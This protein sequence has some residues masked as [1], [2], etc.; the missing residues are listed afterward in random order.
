MSLI[1]PHSFLFN[2]DILHSVCFNVHKEQALLGTGPPKNGGRRVMGSRFAFLL[3]GASAVTL[4]AAA[5]WAQTPAPPSAP[6]PAEAA[7]DEKVVVTGRKREEAIQKLPASATV[8]GGDQLE[9]TQQTTADQVLRTVPNALTTPFGAEYASDVIIRG[10]GSGRSETSESATGIYRNGAYAAGGG[11]GG[12]TLTRMDL[13]DIG[14]LEIFR[15]PQGAS[16]GRNAVGGAINVVSARPQDRLLGSLAVAADDVQSVDIRGVFNAPVGKNAALRLGGLYQAQDDGFYQNADGST[17]DDFSVYGGRASLGFSLSETVNGVF[18]IEASDEDTPSFTV[19]GRYPTVSPLFVRNLNTIPR[20]L[21]DTITSS[22]EMNWDTGIGRFTSVT[23]MR[24]RNLERLD[25]FDASVRIGAGLLTATDSTIDRRDRFE[26]SRFSQELRLSSTIGENVW[27]ILGGE[28]LTSAEDIE[29]RQTGANNTV[30][31]LFGLPDFVTLGSSDDTSWA[32]FGLLGWRPTEAWELT[33]EVRATNDNKTY[34]GQRTQTSGAGA[35]TIRDA[36]NQDRDFSNVS[37]VATLSWSPNANVTGYARLATGYRAGGFNIDS[38]AGNP[39]TQTFDPEDSVSYE[40]GAKTTWF[41]NLLRLNLAAYRMETSDIQ[42]INRNTTNDRYVFNAGDAVVQGL[43][44]D[45]RIFLPLSHQK[46]A[47]LILFGGSLNESE[48]LNGVLQNGAV[49][50]QLAGLEV[51]RA[52]H[53]TANLFVQYR[54]ALWEGSQLR[55]SGSYGA[56]WGGF[57]NPD[58]TEKLKSFQ[59]ADFS[60]GVAFGP[61]EASLYVQNAFDYLF[62]VEQFGGSEFINKPRVAGVRLKFS[63]DEQ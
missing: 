62:V 63:Y 40:L 32:A 27:L 25:D 29:L 6:A 61:W 1:A 57:E 19:Y 48:N 8:V 55:L 53:A 20:V 52:R 44:L 21:T 31:N 30:S 11:A 46:E 51:P 24:D 22:L 58:N 7:Q 3:A 37:P 56:Q 38:Q 33:G 35:G 2:V 42:L 45:G 13:F 28:Y 4:T 17:L 15:G 39:A 59:L 9:A 5:A 43:E 18:M 50:T 16:F 34:I 60:A 14:R 54:R 49:L 26:F 10:A 41:S 36:I 23:L 12:R 47:L